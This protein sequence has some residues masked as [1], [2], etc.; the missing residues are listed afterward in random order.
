VKTARGMIMAGSAILFLTALLHGWGYPK[1]SAEMA[2]SNARPLLVSAFKALWLVYSAHLIVL[3]LIFVAASGIPGGK[4][5]V[6]IG[7]LIPALEATVPFPWIVRR[8]DRG[9]AGRS[10]ASCR[11]AHA[12]ERQPDLKPYHCRR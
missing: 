6:L 1:I 4:R 9:C 8:H 11:R 3:S 2:G 12:A 10:A 5:I 7:L